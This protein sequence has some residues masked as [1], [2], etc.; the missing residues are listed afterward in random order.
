M[1]VSPRTFKHKP[2]SYYWDILRTNMSLP[3]LGCLQDL[4]GS[5][6]VNKIVWLVKDCGKNYIYFKDLAFIHY[7]SDAMSFSE[8][9]SATQI[10][11][12]RTRIA[13][14]TKGRIA[15]NAQKVFRVTMADLQAYGIGFTVEPKSSPPSLLS[16]SGPVT[17]PWI[18]R[19]PLWLYQFTGLNQN[20]FFH[21]WH[22]IRQIWQF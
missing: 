1:N 14:P 15:Q 20:L 22:R 9:T 13:V 8:E 12:H 17:W 6:T 5:Y 7:S 11:R 18:K 19:S 10:F 21:Y 3:L 2:S 16:I 4:H